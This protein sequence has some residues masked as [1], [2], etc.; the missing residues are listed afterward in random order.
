[1]HLAFCENQNQIPGQQ[2]Q[3][4]RREYILTFAFRILRMPRWSWS[5]Q[6]IMPCFWFLSC[7]SHSGRRIIGGSMQNNC[8]LQYNQIEDS[9]AWWRHLALIRTIL[10]T[11]RV[12]PHGWLKSFQSL[13]S[14]YPDHENAMC[15]CTW[16]CVR[17][18]F[19]RYQKHWNAVTML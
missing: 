4:A 17:Y 19:L 13:I 8:D 5:G 9:T 11:L 1:M 10:V 18:S 15:V 6:I 2:M 14:N 12:L 3:G 7:S 16:L